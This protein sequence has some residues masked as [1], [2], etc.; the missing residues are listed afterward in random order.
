MLIVTLW[1]MLAMIW[2]NND[3]SEDLDA[4]IGVLMAALIAFFLKDKQ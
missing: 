4:F 1:I 2:Y 3:L